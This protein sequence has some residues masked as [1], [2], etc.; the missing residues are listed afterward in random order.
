[1]S[2][3]YAEGVL[4]AAVPAS[5]AAATIGAAVGGYYIGKA[6][7]KRVTEFHIIRE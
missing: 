5:A 2:D 4:A 1:L 6:I 7:D 3:F